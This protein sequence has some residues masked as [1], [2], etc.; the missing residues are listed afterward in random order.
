MVGYC[1]LYISSFAQGSIEVDTIADQ[2][3]AKAKEL[4]K[5]R[6][7]DESDSILFI[8]RKRYLDK[9]IWNKWYTTVNRF[10]SN[11]IKQRKHERNIKEITKAQLIAPSDSFYIR[12]KLSYILAN[13]YQYRGDG[14][15]GERWATRQGR[16]P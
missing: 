13:N 2:M 9:K 8:A 12:A 16:S 5:V 3:L 4:S 7:F 10:H 6:S 1:F 11:G 14:G 15:W